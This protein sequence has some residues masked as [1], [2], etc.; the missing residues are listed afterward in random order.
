M[1]TLPT[2]GVYGRLVHVAETFVCVH[3]FDCIKLS[4]TAVYTPTRNVP[5]AG[6]LPYIQVGPK[7]GAT[8]HNSVKSEP[9]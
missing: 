2:Q 1:A 4:I 9:I 3:F 6:V 5:V 7:S 8:G